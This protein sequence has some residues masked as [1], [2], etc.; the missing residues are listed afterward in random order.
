[1]GVQN[2]GF[3]EMPQCKALKKSEI[4]P[5][6]PR[7][8][9]LPESGVFGQF[10]SVLEEEIKSQVSRA[11]RPRY[12]PMTTV[13]AAEATGVREPRTATTTGRVPK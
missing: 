7:M 2:V 10:D 3:E 6:S 9:D 13:E 5:G 11:L 1:M 8:A 4:T 12:G